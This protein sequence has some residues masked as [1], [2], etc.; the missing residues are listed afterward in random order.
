[1]LPNNFRLITIPVSH[2]SEKARWALDYLAVPYREMAHMPPF[3]RN[4]TKK[5]GG[6]SVPVLITDTGAAIDSTD[7][8]RYLDRLY[9]EKLYPIDPNLQ[10]LTLE[11]ENLFNLKL[12]V[13][14]RRWGYSYI[15]SP[16]LLYPRWTLGVPFWE[17]LLFPAIFPRVGKIVR[18][19]YDITETSGA[20]SYREIEIVFDR[21]DGLLADG[22]KYLLGDKFSAIDLT[23]AALAAPILQPPEHHIKPA[24]LESLPAQ[25][26]SDIRKAQA[27]PAGKFGL[28]L[29]REYR[30]NE[31]QSRS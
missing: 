16:Q 9:P 6:T 11:L 23:F 21:V 8:L 2:Y 26:Q 29:Y 7:I 27:T 15:L 20:E 3:H 28:R 1:M 10:V 22:R 5:Y 25:M 17:K 13:H 14:T 31:A 24:E 12:G 30:H 19:T 18:S 4:A